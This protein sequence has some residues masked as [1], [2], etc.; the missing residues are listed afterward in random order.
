MNY[1]NMWQLFEDTGDPLGYLLYRA[2]DKRDQEETTVSAESG[3][4]SAA[5]T[6]IEAS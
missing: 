5:E 1:Q 6:P 4:E 2:Y 3:T